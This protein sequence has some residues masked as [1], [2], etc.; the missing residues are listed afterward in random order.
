MIKQLLALVLLGTSCQLYAQ[1]KLPSDPNVKTGKLANGLT[2]YIRKNQEPKNRAELRLAVKAGSVLEADNQQG[3]AHFVEHMGFNGTKNFKK[4]ELVSFLEKSGVSF[5]ADLNAYTSFDETV[6]EL[7]LPTD[8]PAL[9]KKGFQILADWAHA[10]SFDGTEIDK[11]R[12]V[13]LEE[14]RVRRNAGQRMQYQWLPVVLNGSQYAK[15]IPIGDSLT[16][17]NFKHATLKQFYTDWYRPD[18]QAIIAVGDFD[19]AAVEKMIKDIFGKIPVKAKKPKPSFYFPPHTDIK[20]IIATDPEQQYNIVQVMYK[21]SKAKPVLT[22]ADYRQVL[23]NSLYSEM[24]NMRLQELTQKADAPFLFGN[25]S[26]GELLGGLTSFNLLAV[27]KDGASVQK[28]LDALLTENERIK[29][30]GFT[31][32]ELD[33]AKKSMLS[34]IENRYNERNK[35]NSKAYVNE[36]VNL[37]LKGGVSTSIDTD[38]ELYKQ[39]L[40]QIKLE[41]VNVLIKKW[42]KE[43]DRAVVIMAPEKEKANLPGSEVFA[44]ALN[45]KI[46]DL[47]PYEDKVAKGGLMPSAPVAG[48]V[49]KE[50]KIAALN[51]T[52]WVLSNGA[53]VVV[54]PT[55]FKNDEIQI[56]AIS[57]G[58]KSLMADEDYING[59]NADQ[60]IQYGGIGNL[61]IMEL[62][63]EMTGK[64][65][66]VSP[67]IRNY[68]EGFSGSSTPKDL[69]T[70]M[71][72]L[73][74]YFTQPRK[75]ETM[76]N[77]LKS[78][79]NTMLANKNNNPQAVFA[80]TM[81]YLMSN[82]HPRSKP[83]ETSMIP[84]LN[85]DKAMTL[86]KERFAGADDFIFTFV[87]NVKLDILKILVEKYIASL[88]ATGKKENWKD[89]G[90]R[91]PTGIIEKKVY[92]GKEAKASVRLVFTGEGNYSDEE[93][94]QL[95]QLG[96]ALNIK[97]R[98]NLREEKGG[99]YGTGVNTEL[100]RIPY[101]SYSIE[102]SWTC[103]PA[104]VDELIAAAMSE[105]KKIKE[106]GCTQED[107]QKVIAEDTRAMEVQLRENGYWIYNL[108]DKYRNNED[109]TLILKDME[110]LKKIT[111]AKTKE[112]ANKYFNEKNMIK[113]ILLPE[114]KN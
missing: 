38:F 46:G 64:Q 5:G 107:V 105:I 21:Q 68:S 15:R 1:K 74:L 26:Y 55:D 37:F 29:R 43:T 7:P 20:H 25:S 113:A 4:Q 101:Q 106:N 50:T 59:D 63:K 22:D 17:T 77:V 54:K 48:K 41:E 111:V 13:I 9:F 89:V 86:Y 62:Q 96:K 112:M 2:Y 98:E 85:L 16:L 102:I 91:Y 95:S 84:Q 8:S 11:E 87:G 56:S 30:F 88:P 53:K 67:S 49:V 83:F 27:A 28:S 45:K 90:M 94:T 70:A 80:D 93:A 79:A 32:S 14:R 82:Y 92:K 109:P 51:V 39:I 103:D 100:S 57:Q 23:C 65:A 47:K 40:P 52:E 66:Y 35:T 24:A 6:Y 110:I 44:T 75:D 73:Y 12:G 104:K 10:V 76:F 71:Q 97:L 42:I 36:Y 33:R 18:L 31:Q 3:L 72:L 78:Q 61:G 60:I 19:V 99:T 114:Q 34:S 108:E 69:E 58:G 81:Q